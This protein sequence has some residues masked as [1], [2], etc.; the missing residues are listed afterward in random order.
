MRVTL[1][2]VKGPH[3]GRAFTF[4]Q[5]DTFFVGRSVK[6]HFSLPRHDR[7]FSRMHFLVEVNPP[8][9]RVVDLGSRNGTLVND[10]RVE[11]ADLRHGDRIRAGRSVLE[12][13]IQQQPG[14][15]YLLPTVPAGT[16]EELATQFEKEWRAARAPR[17]EEF[18]ANVQEADRRI[19]LWELALLELELRLSVNDPARVEDF[20][21][22]FPELKNDPDKLADL[23]VAECTFRRRSEPALFAEEYAR[24]FP[25][26]AERLAGRLAPS[27]AEAETMDRS[28]TTR[29]AAAGWPR[30]PGYRLEEE[31]GQGGM[32]VVYRATCV[33]DGRSVAV[34]A[35]RPAVAAGPVAVERF[36]R[37][38]EILRRLK[39]RH[40]VSFRALGE[41]DGFL[42]FAMDLVP[43]T[44]AAQLVGREGPLD[45]QRATR[46]V[47]PVLGA[48]AYAHADGFVHRDIKPGN[49]LVTPKSE[50][51]EARLADFGLARTYQAS[52]LSG[53][54]V[55]G[56]LGGTPLFMAPEQVLSLRD[57]KPPGDQYSM[58]ATL[59]F[60]LTGQAPYNRAANTQLQL[61]QILEEDPIPLLQ[62]RP[63]L[64]GRLENVIHRALGRDPEDRYPDVAGF[65]AA[66]RPFAD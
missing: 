52:R 42:W 6:A 23:V 11:S 45:V 59:Y 54:T 26:L 33:S 31:L 9:V 21:K 35:I 58:A 28:A 36:L 7:Y 49:L 46:L 17:I 27:R 1:T 3:A 34:K 51:E 20:L 14:D 25:E 53:L 47:L 50:G 24:R 48:L 56:A 43:G 19:L 12:V 15:D 2:V 16:V 66:L 40:I 30:I 37:E 13:A 8:L 29:A 41:A 39:H 22:R 62:R 57:V 10:A 44:N 63:D 18:V 61:M 38:A 64:P 5:H 4:D 32:G 55:V 60:L 65:A